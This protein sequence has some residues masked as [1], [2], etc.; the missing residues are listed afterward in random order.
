M[1]WTRVQLLVLLL[2][3]YNVPPTPTEK[4]RVRDFSFKLF[5]SVP[6]VY[7][8][9]L[10]PHLSVVVHVFTFKTFQPSVTHIFHKPD[11]WHLVGWSILLSDVVKN[12]PGVRLQFNDVN[13][14]SKI[15]AV[16]A[17]QGF[18]ILDKIRCRLVWLYPV[19]NQCED[20]NWGQGSEQYKTYCRQGF[21]TKIS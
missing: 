12:I 16:F 13:L 7:M 10:V 5:D 14:C 8:A 2:T 9:L 19:Q 4:V 1:Y 3:E 20:S 11:D 18:G 21:G 6:I 17:N 15:C